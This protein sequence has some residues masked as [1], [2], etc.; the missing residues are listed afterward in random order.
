MTITLS[1]G[2]PTIYESSAP[3][4]EVL[5]GTN[6]GVIRIERNGADWHITDRTLTDLH[7]HAILK[8][9]HSGLVFAGANRGSVH[10]SRDDGR[11][12][13]KSDAGL[14]ETN[15]YSLN[16]VRRKN[17][18]TRIYLGTEPARIFFS[19]DLG[20][21]WTELPNFRNVPG[22]DAWRF[23]GP[24]HIAHL[25][26]I[27]FAKDDP[28]TIYGSIEVGALLR[29]RD[30]GQ[31]WD[32]ITPEYPDIHRCIIPPT[33]P[34]RYYVTGGNGMYV[35]SDGGA[36]WEHWTDRGS[37]I[38][39]YPDQLVYHPR[40]PELM[41]VCAAHKSPGAWAEHQHSGSRFA[42]S[43]DGGR[44]WEVL[45][46]G[47]PDRLQGSVESMC[48]DTYG[49]GGTLLIGTSTGQIWTSEDLGDSWS[50]A[51]DGLAPISKGDH[52]LAMKEPVYPGR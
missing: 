36:S 22:V 10:V 49:D 41:F 18:H 17:G 30:E 24:P 37:D 20:D 42:R 33:N 1:H 26:H 38:G 4:R 51:I 39:G 47:L 52:Y 28:E 46:H 19:D 34:D 21:S 32:V 40:N 13:T 31:T 25:K 16:S 14:A 23:P 35:T 12:W 3:E 48:F 5:V 15:V 2:G 8:E 9:P 45:T 44:S 6:E 29:S 50:V 7:I 43:R 11:T 27:N